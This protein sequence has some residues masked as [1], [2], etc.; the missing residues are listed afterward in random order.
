MA[1]CILSGRSYYCCIIRLLLLGAAKGP[2]AKTC[3]HDIE[4]V[5]LGNRLGGND[6]SEYWNRDTVICIGVSFCGSWVV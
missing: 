3:R 2:S 5:S 4:A 1:T 6:S